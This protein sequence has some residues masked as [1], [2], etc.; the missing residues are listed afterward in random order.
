MSSSFHAESSLKIVASLSVFL[1]S[2]HKVGLNQ[3]LVDIGF[4]HAPN[5]V[6]PRANL[7]F[8]GKESEGVHSKPYLG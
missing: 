6:R 3:Y 2:S 8:S 1:W 5:L 7:Y 4:K